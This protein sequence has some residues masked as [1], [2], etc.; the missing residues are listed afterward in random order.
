MTRWVRFEVIGIEAIGRIGEVNNG[1]TNYDAKE[2]RDR[3]HHVEE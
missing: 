1:A 3:R 2:H